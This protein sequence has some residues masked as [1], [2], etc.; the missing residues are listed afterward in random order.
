MIFLNPSGR[1]ARRAPRRWL[2]SMAI[3]ILIFTT[4]AVPA[5]AADY[6]VAKDGRD[7]NTG[8]EAAPWLTIGKAARALHAGDTVHVKQGTYHERVT[9]QVQGSA[10]GGYITLQNYQNDTVIVDGAGFNLLNPWGGVIEAFGKSYLRIQGFHVQ[11]AQGG[12]SI[13][14]SG[15]GGASHIEINDNEVSAHHGINAIG[16]RG[17]AGN[18]SQVIVDGNE[19]HDCDTGSQEALRIDKG[20]YDFIVRNNQVH[21]NTNIG[22]D[23]VGWGTQPARGWISNNTCYRNGLNADG[24]HGIYV[25]GGTYVTIED[26]FCFDN[27]GGIEVGA[28]YP[29]E[30]A[31]HII[32]RRNF[33]YNN[34]RRG[35]SLG[36]CQSCGRPQDCAIVHNVAYNNNAAAWANDLAVTYFSGDH[37]IKNNIFYDTKTSSVYL[38]YFTGDNSAGQ[39]TSDYNCHTPANAMYY[40]Q[41]TAYSTLLAWQAVTGQDGHSLAGNP[42]FVNS[43]SL[44][45]R[46]S[47]GSACI[48]AGAFLTRAAASGSGTDLPVDNAT[49][50]CDGY[51]G[52]F[53][54]DV[55]RIGA[56]S[57]VPITQVDYVSRH[58][59]L[60]QARTWNLNDG[61]SLDYLG[62]APDI[63]AYEYGMPVV[64]GQFTGTVTD[65]DTGTLL[66]GA[67]IASGTTLAT[68]DAAGG[69][70]LEL[71]PGNYTLICSCPGYLAQTKSAGLLPGGRVI[72]DWQ[73]TTAAQARP[74]EDFTVTPGAYVQ[75]RSPSDKIHFGNLPQNATIR[76]Y[77][78]SGRLLHTLVHQSASGGEDWDVG[79]LASG[80][81]LYH[82]QTDQKE[83]H[84]KIA[85]VR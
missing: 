11:N 2:A 80:I 12:T 67:T 36:S 73:L 5:A 56:Q 53:A 82:I 37:Q 20:T 60:A 48:D 40:Y 70:R 24:A 13:L 46:L 49:A 17:G 4:A 47:A 69:Y 27:W 32:V 3:G 65:R 1:N 9:I 44:D 62:S 52:L 77:T 76:I 84:G 28:E 51:G 85:V 64:L 57:P 61:V 59:T 66:R 14:V 21:D 55:I 6:Y 38:M 54:G 33:V 79:G 19:V 83:K 15:D 39:V 50:F 72:L 81:Y 26:N 35:I 10:A 18:L 63:G 45:F 30:I 41:G 22:I 68:A 25:D 7:S 23:V 78:V 74:E 42:N 75:G 29:G 8:S 43:A 71:P 16:V 34:W 31:H 58:L